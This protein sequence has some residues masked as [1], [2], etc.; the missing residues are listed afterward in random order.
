VSFVGAEDQGTKAASE[1]AQQSSA[2]HS[3]GAFLRGNSLMRSFFA[4]MTSPLKYQRNVN[5]ALYN[6]ARSVAEGHRGNPKKAREAFKQLFYAG[7]IYHVLLPQLFQAVAT[8]VSALVDPDDED[9]MEKAWRRQL[10]ALMLGNASVFPVLG[11]LW[12]A[13]SNRMSGANEAFLRG[14]GS[15][16]LD[17]ASDVVFDVD[18]VMGK[19]G[20]MDAWLR[21]L[22]SVP[23]L[24][25]VPMKTFV[26]QY[27]ALQETIEGETDNPLLRNLGWSKWAII[28]D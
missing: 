14:S 12:S 27:E 9:R 1:R 5:V 18:R 16:L 23:E 3:R 4:F 24:G 21:L 11:Q 22:Q 19:P 13:A 28:E 20:E 2:I 8:G 26:R 10:R 7:A 17:S 15:P 6:A 25:G